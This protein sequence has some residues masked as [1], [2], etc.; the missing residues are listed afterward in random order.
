MTSDG[1]SLKILN[2]MIGDARASAIT[3]KMPAIDAVDTPPYRTL[4]SSEN[5]ALR[6]GACASQGLPAALVNPPPDIV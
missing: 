1:E 6:M 3:P 4:Y 2:K 5:T